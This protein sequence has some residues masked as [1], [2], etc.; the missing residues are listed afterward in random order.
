ME[1]FGWPA[2][3]SNGSDFKTP[4]NLVIADATPERRFVRT[5]CERDNA[6]VVDAWLK[7]TPVGFYSIQYA[8]KKGEPPSAENSV[9]TASSSKATVF[10]SSRLRETKR[11]AN[12]R[13]RM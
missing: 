4:V 12:L 10:S 11:S 13:L 6:K 2:A 7:N 1:I 9:P 8:W 5:L 3:C